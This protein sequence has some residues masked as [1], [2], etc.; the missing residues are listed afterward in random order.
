MAEI[1]FF[2]FLAFAAL[3]IIILAIIGRILAAVIWL[4]LWLLIISLGS[5]LRSG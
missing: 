4:A 1:L 5:C 3:L 2:A